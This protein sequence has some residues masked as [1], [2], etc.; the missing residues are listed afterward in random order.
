MLARFETLILDMNATFMFGHDRFSDAEDFGSFFCRAGG[1]LSAQDASRIISK[2]FKYLAQCYPDPGF[3]ESFP[4]VRAALDVVVPGG[5]ATEKDLDLLVET[6]AHYERGTGSPEF[7]AAVLKLASTH[8]LGL[9]ADIW[10]PRDSWLVEFRRAGIASAFQAMSF[11][12]DCGI[13]KPSPEPFK[14]VLRSL[15][16]DPTKTVVIGDSARRDLGGATAAGLPCILVGGAQDKSALYSVE[17]LL[18]LQ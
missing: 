18:C 10:A 17:S 4:S 16:A 11:S 3:R 2:V 14:R 9:V 8:K 5:V 12:S 7:A 1:S 6:F 15:K 13:V